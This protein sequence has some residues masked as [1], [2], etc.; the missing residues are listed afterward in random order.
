MICSESHSEDEQEPGLNPDKAP[1]VPEVTSAG[2]W[3][4]RGPVWDPGAEG[5]CSHSAA[6]MGVPWRLAH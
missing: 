2:A 6:T 3:L 5:S 4:H 1:S